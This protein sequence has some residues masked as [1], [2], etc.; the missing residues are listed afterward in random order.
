[1]IHSHAGAGFESTLRDPVSEVDLTV[2]AAE[3]GYIFASRCDYSEQE[4]PSSPTSIR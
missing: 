1:V 2:Q 3:V 4:S